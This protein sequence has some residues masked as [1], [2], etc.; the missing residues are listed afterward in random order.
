MPKTAV[1]QTSNNTTLWYLKPQSTSGCSF[2]GGSFGPCGVL[3]LVLLSAITLLIYR[4]DIHAFAYF[5]LAGN[6][7][8]RA[9][10]QTALHDYAVVGV[11]SERYH[12]LVCLA[13]FDSP[14]E[15][16]IIVVE[17][18]G[19]YRNSEPLPRRRS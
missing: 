19:V 12:C 1:M 13:V 10:G 8:F 14:Y 4:C 15:R 9:V 16:L 5:L 18:N 17:Q 7:I 2:T 11:G 3:L 6:D